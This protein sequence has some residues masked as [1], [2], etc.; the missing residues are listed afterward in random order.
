MCLSWL[1]E[2][3]WSDLVC[4]VWLIDL[5]LLCVLPLIRNTAVTPELLVSA[6]ILASALVSLFFFVLTSRVGVLLW[7]S[8]ASSSV[9]SF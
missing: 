3:D 1:P 4:V 9:R 8:E 5:W 7:S 2:L 6:S